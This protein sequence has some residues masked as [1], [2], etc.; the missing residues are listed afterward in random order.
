MGK[1]SISNTNFQ[2]NVISNPEQ[3]YIIY[4]TGEELILENIYFNE[5][6]NAAFCSGPCPT[7][8][9]F[10]TTYITNPNLE[11]FDCF[12]ITPESTPLI[13]PF[14]TPLTTPFTTP[15]TT[16]YETPFI[17]PAITTINPS[18]SE[19][20]EIEPV[21][22]S[23]S[24]SSSSSSSSTTTTT[25]NEEADEGDTDPEPQKG[26][27]SGTIIGVIV[28][29]ILAVIV[30]VCIIIFIIVRR[31]NEKEASESG[32]SSHELPEETAVSFVDENNSFETIPLY[33]TEVD[34]SDPFENDFE[35]YD[36]HLH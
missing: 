4:N 3:K 27:V 34:S 7:S 19:S 28:G 8:I 32:S 23:D 2:N 36:Y 26:G 25:T 24:S 29:C 5:D 20:S 22:P 6:K 21:D 10:T 17:T 13:T 33:T 11:V 9:K 30:V 31:R 15:L 16:P 12:I 14:T 18:E 35:E 1:N